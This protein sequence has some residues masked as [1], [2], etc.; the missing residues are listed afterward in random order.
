MTL[1]SKRGLGCVVPLGRPVGREL[2]TW[3]LVPRRPH[4]QATS[5]SCPLG[6]GLQ[7]SPT[8]C[9]WFH[10]PCSLPCPDVRPLW[11]SLPTDPA[12]ETA[13]TTSAVDAFLSVPGT[14]VRP[15]PGSRPL[16]A[17]SAGASVGEP[18]ADKPPLGWDFGGRVLIFVRQPSP[19]RLTYPSGLLSTS[20]PVAPRAPS[21]LPEPN[22][23][24]QS[25]ARPRPV[26]VCGTR[27]GHAAFAY[28][29]A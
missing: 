17:A 5:A 27:R 18:F 2:R 26:Q 24:R 28:Q 9:V 15:G 19:R 10:L 16:V 29:W 12:Q 7:T 11:P 13:W 4:G 6:L 21:S 14:R 8:T 22:Q 20:T 3:V 23:R 1:A 25:G